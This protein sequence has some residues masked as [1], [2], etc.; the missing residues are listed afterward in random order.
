[1]T[2]ILHPPIIGRAGRTAS[3]E[4][5]LAY[6]GSKRV[7]RNQNQ[8]YVWLTL[9]PLQ[10]RR[11]PRCGSQSGVR[12]RITGR[13]T[14][15]TTQPRRLGRQRWRRATEHREPRDSAVA[16]L[17]PS[18]HLNRSIIT[19]VHIEYSYSHPLPPVRHTPFPDLFS[20]S[21]ALG[22]IPISSR[23]WIWV[24]TRL[25][26]CRVILIH[27]FLAASPLRIR[28]VCRPTG[29]SKLSGGAS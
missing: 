5:F 21:R 29:S 7:Q 8:R 1:M 24:S 28:V 27:S 10:S 3:L 2:V 12:S 6:S 13:S 15:H 14:S 25:V 20:N 19:A 11:S 17:W 9:A 23:S 4:K 22:P 16:A 26:D 18:M